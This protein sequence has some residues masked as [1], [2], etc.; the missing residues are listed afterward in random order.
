MTKRAAVCLSLALTL[1]ACRRESEAPPPVPPVAEASREP[2][3][4]EVRSYRRPEPPLSAVEP[5]AYCTVEH[6]RYERRSG[7]W[8]QKGYEDRPAVRTVILGQDPE[9]E[10]QISEEP[11]LEPVLHLGRVRVW[12]GE[13][14]V[15]AM[16][17]DFSHRYEGAVCETRGKVRLPRNLGPMGSALEEQLPRDSHW[18]R[19]SLRVR[20]VVDQDGRVRELIS[21]GG[22]SQYSDLL[23]QDLRE[24]RFQPAT[25]DGHP[26]AVVHSVD[27][28]Y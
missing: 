22:L 18:R 1:V 6:R 12:V 13:D 26:V 8:V 19:R 17:D 2:A 20:F 11:W 27:L 21:H 4:A 23:L 5:D 7:V 24:V 9:L 25:L 16:N 28:R 10:K 14:F 3:S 15:E